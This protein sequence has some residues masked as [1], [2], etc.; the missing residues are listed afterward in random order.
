MRVIPSWHRTLIWFAPI[1]SS[2]QANCS[3]FHFFGSRTRITG[4]PSALNPEIPDDPPLFFTVSLIQT[5]PQV[6]TN[7]VRHDEYMDQGGVWM[8]RQVTVLK[9]I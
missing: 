2:A 4:V 8:F 5:T 3:R 6:N 1:I 9:K 7:G